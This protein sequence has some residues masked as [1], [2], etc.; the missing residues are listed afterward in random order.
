[1]HAIGRRSFVGS[2]LGVAALGALGRPLLAQ[3]PRARIRLA[4]V[5]KSQTNL[6]FQA[7]AR[8][9]R[10][11]A[12]NVGAARGVR[13]DMQWRTPLRE[14]A[15]AQAEI[16]RTLAGEGID[17]IAVSA[18]NPEAATPAID[19][20]VQKGVPV[21]CFDADAPGSRRFAYY[22]E[23]NRQIG[24]RVIDEL[25][26]AIGGEGE[27]GILISNEKGSTGRER[28]QGALAAIADRPGITLS[29]LGR[30][31]HD[32]TIAAG[33]AALRDAH[34]KAP[35]LAGWA[36]LSGF[37]LFGAG[38]LPWGV[39]GPRVVSVDA[40]PEQLEYLRMGLVQALIAQ[41]CYAWGTRSVEL[42]IERIIDGASP[43]NARVVAPLEVVRPADALEWERRW[44][45]WLRRRP[46]R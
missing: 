41:N 46:G 13:I 6:V 28:V 26:D 24:A 31:H 7:A 11:A 10:D 36:L 4:M 20:A 25:A 32:E 17:G 12:Q 29:D 42:L 33:R 9:A 21:L 14:D 16:I 15:D 27:I 1:M 8:G 19:A 3:E 23:D 45:R 43:P 37:P 30:V 22:G 5:A 35:D 34:A 38:G 39:G 44:D 2:A 40:L 18:I